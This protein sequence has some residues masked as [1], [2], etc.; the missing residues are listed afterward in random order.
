[1]T[2]HLTSDFTLTNVDC[3]M[4]WNLLPKYKVSGALLAAIKGMY[5]R[6]KY[7]IY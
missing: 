2:P 6:T 4:L 3:E 1:M 5:C 7:Y